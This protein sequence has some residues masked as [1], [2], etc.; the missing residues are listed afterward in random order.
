MK[1]H[2]RIQR[3]ITFTNEQQE[4]VKA[5]HG[6]V[7]IGTLS[8]MLGLKYNKVHNNLQLMGLVE[9]RKNTAKI[10]KMRGYF[11]ID[12]FQRKYYEY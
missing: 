7:N 11:D 9:S 6:K 4:Y 1:Q 3:N 12:D 5:N 2:V 10:V 8:K